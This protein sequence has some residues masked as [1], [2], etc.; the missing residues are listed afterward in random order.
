MLIGIIANITKENVFSVVSSFIKELKK[1]NLEYLLTKTLLEDKSKLK[2][3]LD[4][5]FLSDDKEIYKKSDL[6]ISIGGDGTM[7]ATAYHALSY[8]KPVLG[9]NIGKLGFLAEVD[10]SQMDII[11]KDIKEGNYQIQERMV[12]TADCDTY[13]VEKLIAI[14][15]IVIDKGGWPK[16]IEITAQVDGE[17]VSTFSADG[18]IIATPIGSTGYSL[19]TGGPVVSPSAGAITLSPISPHSLTMRPLVLSSE[20]EIVIKADSPHIEIQISCD[21]QR[22]YHIP[23]PL[24]I[25]IVKSVKPLKLVHTSV[26]T[27]FETLRNKLLWGIDVRRNKINNEGYDS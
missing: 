21:G 6:I 26:T 14:N 18:V 16:M 11:I 3:E 2:I 4:E 13:P 12:L 20:Q 27:Y 5:D 8:D 22:V 9:L 25:K 7:L 17:Y 23:P 19:S 15:D 24:E 1:N 10:I